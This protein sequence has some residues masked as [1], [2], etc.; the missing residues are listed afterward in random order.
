MILLS[1]PRL[2]RLAMAWSLLGAGVLAGCSTMDRSVA[3]VDEPVVEVPVGEAADVP[4]PVLAEAL[5]RAGLSRTQILT[6][7]PAI[8][9]ALATNG[10]AQVREDKLVIA[11]LA[12]H[13]GQLIVTSRERGT[14]MVPLGAPSS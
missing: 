9:N 14:F 11:L 2:R 12:V 7:G 3:L 6:E 4:A 13:D 8:R 5:L 10:G 1:P